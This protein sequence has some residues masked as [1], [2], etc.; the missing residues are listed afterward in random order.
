MPSLLFDPL[1]IF[2]IPVKGHDSGLPV[3][4]IFCVGR[5]YAAHA[6]EMGG[7]VD[8]EAPWYFT[9]SV[10]HAVLS[11]AE[12]PYPSGTENYHHEMELA[13]AIG[14]EVSNADEAEAA[15]AIFAFGCALDMTRRDRQQD[16]KDNRRPWSLGKDVENSAVFA[17]M[18]P[19][20]DFGALGNQRISL[21]VDGKIRQDASLAEMVWSPIELVMHLSRFYTLH[22]GDVVMTGTPAGVGPVSA[23]QTVTGFIDGLD[24]ISLSLTK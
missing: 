21:E 14:L 9:K 1:P 17:R 6:A 20:E 24:P 2:V 16:G 4:R 13:F 18:T 7:E 19:V 22:P 10:A 8:R 12:V 15:G 5:N 23:G 3:R 11:G